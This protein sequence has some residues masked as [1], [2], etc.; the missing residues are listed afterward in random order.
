V[1]KKG[2]PI[3]R[4]HPYFTLFS[5]ALWPGYKNLSNLSKETKILQP[6]SK[7][8]QSPPCLS[9]F[10]WPPVVRLPELL[11]ECVRV[12]EAW[13]ALCFDGCGRSLSFYGFG[14]WL[15]SSPI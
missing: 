1:L 4:E 12:A 13:E 11:T 7:S 3:F 10:Q 9:S 6:T 15:L 8:I 2:A 5:L 14:C